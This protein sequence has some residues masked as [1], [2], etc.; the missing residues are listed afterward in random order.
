MPVPVR[1]LIVVAGLGLLAGCTKQ[2]TSVLDMQV[3][4][5][6]WSDYRR[7]L[8]AIDARQTPEE[9]KEF[10]EAMQEMKFQAML[11]DHRMSTGSEINALV[12][13][14]VAGLSVRD[15][16]VLNLTIKLGRKQ[17][18]ETALIRAITK[19]KRLRT[20]EGDNASAAFLQSVQASQ[21][22]QLESVRA[23][24]AAL[25]K[26]INELLPGHIAPRAPVP[27]A[28]EIVPGK[29]LDDAPQLRQAAPPDPRKTA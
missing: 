25:E 1:M 29:D 2:P 7:S 8:E 18:Q 10:T 6:D 23:E 12:R 17:E 3:S 26:R 21:P 22:R 15:V 13:A 5:G 24:I 27:P 11:G 19:N 9:R 20:R 16:L 4:K 14:Q 28:D